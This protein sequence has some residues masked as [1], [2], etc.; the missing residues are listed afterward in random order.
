M[1]EQRKR[2]EEAEVELKKANEKICLLEE[3]LRKTNKGFGEVQRGLEEANRNVALIKQN[4][5]TVSQKVSCSQKN[6]R[7]KLF[8]QFIRL[9][10]N[11]LNI[12]F[13][14]ATPLFFA[15]VNVNV[16][17]FPATLMMTSVFLAL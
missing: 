5:K 7:L 6:A 9:E 3:E 14:P 16:S 1:K 8:C 10:E 2:S 4:M 13:Y 11:Q 12:F 17:V 15:N